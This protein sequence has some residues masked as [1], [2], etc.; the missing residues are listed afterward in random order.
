MT[1]VQVVPA[2]MDEYKVLLAKDFPQ[3]HVMSIRYL[4]SGWD[5]AAILVNEEFVFRFPRGLFEK[6]ERLKTDEIEKEV[7]ILNYLKGKV[8]FATPQPTFVTPD[9]RYFGY[10]LVNGTLW[11]R[12]DKAKQFSDE[13]LHSWV[14]IRCE[15]SK[16]IPVEKAPELKIPKY[17][18][19]RNEELVGKYLADPNGDERV[20]KL[21]KEAMDYVCGQLA[22]NHKWRF[23]HEDLQL[24][25]C[26]VDDEV[27]QIVG[28]IDWG[29]A[30]IGPAEADFYFWSKYGR[31]ML[32]KVAK[33]QEEYDGTK[34][35]V[36]LAEAIHQFYIAADF[37][38]F[39]DRGF[40]ES[41]AHKWRQIEAYL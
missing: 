15:L 39:T 16:A 41:A 4:G 22:S 10:T 5:N 34:I 33:L 25:N 38:D 7:N 19:S 30:E 3:L 8:S 13:L 35:D 32:D 1:S 24:S 23:I 36:R 28:V 11:D 40:A 26:M 17:K 29:E 18:T 12:A 20:K 14:R 31:E 9:F 37:V 6:S 27:K 21:A 2:S